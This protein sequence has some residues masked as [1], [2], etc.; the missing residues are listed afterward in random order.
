MS[1][2]GDPGKLDRFMVF[3]E[4]RSG[5]N[6]VEAFLA[7]NLPLTATSEFGWKH[8]VP[9]YPVLPRR[10]LFVVVVRDAFDWLC[11]FYRA[12]FEAPRT[13]SDLTF[14]E[15]LRSP[16]RSNFNRQ[17]RGWAVQGYRLRFKIA[18]R[19]ELQSDR[20]PLTGASIEN[21]VAL[22]TMKLTGHLSLLNRGI[23]AVALRYEDFCNDPN[24]LLSAIADQF[25]L[26]LPPKINVIDNY[27]G[28]QY[29]GPRKLD[30]IGF[31]PED[32]EFV[33]RHLDLNLEAFCGYTYS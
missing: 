2:A 1:S 15:F 13:I 10:C 25:T 26:E 11:S 16:W 8:G 31:T 28:P 3:G 33:L 20:H 6:A 4:R 18:P 32:R 5:T 17:G 9:S 7:A 24:A 14:P 19:E 22:R 21:V 27:V 30:T 23:N 29:G 12:P